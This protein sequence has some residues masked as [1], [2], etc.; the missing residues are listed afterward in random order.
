MV[1]DNPIPEESESPNKVNYEAHNTQFGG[2]A[3]S[4]KNKCIN[5]E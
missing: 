3:S 4:G 5:V 1:D 2:P